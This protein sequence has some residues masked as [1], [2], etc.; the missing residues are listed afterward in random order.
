MTFF[1]ILYEYFELW[2]VKVRYLLRCLDSFKI[3]HA[4]SMDFLCLFIFELLYSCE[5]EP[6]VDLC[7][8]LG[9]VHEE[10]ISAL[11]FGRSNERLAHIGYI[12]EQHYV[13]F[14]WSVQVH[15]R[16]RRCALYI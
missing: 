16:R 4:N 3:L 12:F 2:V 8:I 7:L 5:I 13:L 6:S 1:Y 10:S 9:S 14:V 11:L 15:V